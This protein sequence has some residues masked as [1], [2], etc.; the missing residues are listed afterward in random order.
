M[1]EEQKLYAESLLPE[2]LKRQGRHKESAKGSKNKD[3]PSGKG[4]SSTVG[5][6]LQNVYRA[7]HKR[8]PITPAPEVVEAV[9]G[10][11]EVV[12]YLIEEFRNNVSIN[13]D[14]PRHS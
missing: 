12:Q 11:M 10:D 7:W 1:S 4:K 2:F 13:K 14:L 5:P 6:W 8:W 3:D 9:D